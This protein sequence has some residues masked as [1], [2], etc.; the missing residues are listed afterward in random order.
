MSEHVLKEKWTIWFHKIDNSNYDIDSY[1]KVLKF[2]TI[3]KFVLLYRK[4][5]NF[6]AGMFFLMKNDIPPLW[7]NEN[8]IKGGYLSLKVYK[9]TINDYWF[10]FCSLIIGQ[11]LIKEN[12]EDINGISVSPKINNCIIKIWF[13]EKK[14]Y[15]KYF[16][17]EYLSKYFDYTIF[18]ESRFIGHKN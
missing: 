8:N 12:M 2:D 4:I 5:N 10:K 9:K 13:K 1:E 3:E 18:E 7:E 6:S 17:K 14:D 11:T 15:K 16:D